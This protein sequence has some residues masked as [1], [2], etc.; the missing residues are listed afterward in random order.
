[1]KVSLLKKTNKPATITAL[2]LTVAIAISAV[3]I[4]LASW[5]TQITGNGTVTANAAWDV[6]ITDA[7]L[8]V[9]DPGAAV[10]LDYLDYELAKVCNINLYG[11]TC[12][13]AS[14]PRA[15][16][17][18]S[19][20]T[21]TQ[22]TGSSYKVSSWLW[23]V[24]TTRFDT[25]IL[26]QYNTEERRLAMLSGLEDGSVI[27]LSD[28]NTAP[29]GTQVAPMKAWYYYKSTSDFFG[30][31]N[32]QETIINGVISESNTIIRTLRPDTYHN[33]ALICIASDNTHNAEHL[34]FVIANMQPSD[35]VAPSPVSFTDTTVNYSG[36]NFTMP[37][38]WA[39]Y[40]LTVANNGTVP[41]DL[42]DTA[43]MIDG[44]EATFTLEAPELENKIINPGESAVLTF[45]V[46]VNSTES[47]VIS[48]TA[49]VSVSLICS[50]PEV[51][52][53]PEASIKID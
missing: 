8:N 14:V 5:H 6:K 11:Q 1:M 3:G 32:A 30:D 10:V 37:G 22:S 17:G 26:G 2:A 43:I 36:V 34:Q 52:E 29:D 38:A 47:A 46:K 13:E 31:S 35:G 40:T 45:N 25:T 42:S 15:S 50:Q 12:I 39:S 21:G 33:Y 44:D 24:D 4:G 27:R 7:T 41:A 9:S 16:S 53:A 18:S 19:H 28:T 20:A 49:N 23:L 51:S 48:G